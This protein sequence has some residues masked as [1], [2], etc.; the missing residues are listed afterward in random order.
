MRTAASAR[1]WPAPRLCSS[2]SSTA[3]E[4][5]MFGGPAHLLGRERGCGRGRPVPGTRQQVAARVDDGNVLRPQSGHRG[6]D[7]VQDCLDAL[8]VQPPRAR[9]GQHHAG[10][11]VLPVARERLAPR[12]HQDARAPRGY[13]AWR[14]WCGRSRPPCARVS[15]IFCWNSV[16]ANSI[17][18]VEHF[19][20]DRSAGGQALV[21][22][23]R[24]ASAT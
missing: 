8:L 18:T 6:G 5:R 12:Q 20:A 22:Q 21:G 19:V 10:L 2:I 1:T 3:R 24:R 4:S 17:A 11:C 23:V 7:E 14:G 16:A 15:L 9:H 13:P